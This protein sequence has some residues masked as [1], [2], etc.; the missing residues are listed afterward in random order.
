MSCRVVDVELRIKVAGHPRVLV[1]TGCAAV[2]IQVILN[3]EAS[4]FTVVLGTISTRFINLA[5]CGLFPDD[6]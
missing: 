4:S 1:V 6:R 3:F 2:C 5:S